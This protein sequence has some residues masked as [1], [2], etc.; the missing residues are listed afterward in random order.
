MAIRITALGVAAL[1]CASGVALADLDKYP[2]WTVPAL[3]EKNA[4]VRCVVGTTHNNK[5]YAS[6]FKCLMNNLQQA[7]KDR[8]PVKATSWLR[9]TAR[10]ARE[11]AK[12]ASTESPDPSYPHLFAANIGMAPMEFALVPDGDEKTV[13]DLCAITQGSMEAACIAHRC[14]AE[15]V[16]PLGEVFARTKRQYERR[17]SVRL[18]CSEAVANMTP[19]QCHPLWLEGQSTLRDAL[20]ANNRA[21]ESGK[22]HL[23]ADWLE[24]S[25]ELQAVAQNVIEGRQEAG[26]FNV[27]R[28]KLRTRAV[29]G[30]VA[31]HQALVADYDK[32][33]VELKGHLARFELV[34]RECRRRGVACRP[35]PPEGGVK[36][37]WPLRWIG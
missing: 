36:R 3:P 17:C 12:L 11:L 15:E 8:E 21:S 24:G 14:S 22:R 27:E 18:E 7:T 5:S 19:K 25:I 1:A 2:P 28:D 32:R 13:D 34:N 4:T 9:E 30:G 35:T 33:A 10:V 37:R 29:V 26:A 31:L 6:D 20:A 16:R 23:V